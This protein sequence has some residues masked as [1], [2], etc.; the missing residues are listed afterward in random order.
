MAYNTI[1][2][3]ASSSSPLI[4]GPAS[5]EEQVD[6]IIYPGNLCDIKRGNVLGIPTDHSIHTCGQAGWQLSPMIIALED[7]ENGKTIDVRYFPGER[8]PVRHFRPGD[9]F[10]GRIHPTG[11]FDQGQPFGASGTT[12]GRFNNTTLW[13]NALCYAQE[14]IEAGA[15][16]RLVPLTVK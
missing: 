15:D 13:G 1:I 9:V 16:G 5:D 7:I 12:A 2:L 8:V 4:E 10:L 14:A 3:S 11:A 6:E